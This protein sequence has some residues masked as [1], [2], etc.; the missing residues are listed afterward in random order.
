LPI[1]ENLI[2]GKKCEFCL[3]ENE[4]ELARAPEA[5]CDQGLG[6]LV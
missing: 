6:R 1:E 5:S 4:F 3:F 2:A